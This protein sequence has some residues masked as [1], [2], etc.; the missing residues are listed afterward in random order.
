M[1]NIGIHQLPPGIWTL[2]QRLEHVSILVPPPSMHLGMLRPRHWP[3]CVRPWHDIP[4]FIEAA[5]IMFSLR[6][7]ER[8]K[9]LTYNV[10][11]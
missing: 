9:E 6:T 8:F 4:R 5:T 2:L 10:Y 1:T 7:E 11:S 3:C